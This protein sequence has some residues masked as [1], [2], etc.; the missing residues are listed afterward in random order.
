MATGV[1]G[2]GI[3][4]AIRQ[5]FDSLPTRTRILGAVMVVLLGLVWIVGVFVFVTGSLDSKAADLETESRKLRDLRTLETRFLTANKQI[6]EAEERLAKNSGVAPT[7]FLE[8]T[9]KEAGI[10]DQVTSINAE[11]SEV[12]GSLKQTRVRVD[13]RAAPVQ[14]TLEFIHDIESSG[15]MSVESTNM[16]TKFLSGEKKL[17]TTIELIA[18]ASEK[19]K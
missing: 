1:S 15:F 8:K 5:Q 4:G 9:A 12:I 2:G 6:A 13:L 19:E 17:T 10:F 7:A 11:G 3:R 18:Y 16:R 14:G